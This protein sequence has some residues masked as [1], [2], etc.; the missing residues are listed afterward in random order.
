[1]S[2][3]AIVPA[4]G[5]DR[6]G[7]PLPSGEPVVVRNVVTYPRRTDETDTGSVITGIN[8]MFPRR[9]VL[10]DAVDSVLVDVRLT[11]DGSLVEGTGTAY[12]VVGDPGVWSYLD[13]SLAGVEVALRRARG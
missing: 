12:E 9:D 10:P 7:D 1:M 3:V 5:T 6:W 4:G 11:T 2:D 8:A 13:G